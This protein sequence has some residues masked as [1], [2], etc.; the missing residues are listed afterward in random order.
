MEN[1]ESAIEA[2]DFNQQGIAL[3]KAGNYE[4][5]AKKYDKAIEIDPMVMESYIN[6]G[7]LYLKTGQYQKAKNYYKKALLF[8]KNGEVYFH[9]G[10]A[11]FM[12]DEPGEGLEYYNLAISAG[13]NND[14]MLF[15][16]GMAYENM[17][18]NG[19][20]L[21][22]YTKAIQ[23]NHMR[24]EYKVKKI[25][26]MIKLN[27]MDEVKKSVD[28]LIME[29][30]ELFDGY[31]LKTLILFEDNDYEKAAEFAKSASE[32][33]PS[34]TDLLY[35]YARAVSLTGRLDD[36][37]KIIENAKKLKFFDESKDRFSLLECE[38]YATGG[39]YDKALS[40]SEECLKLIND[41]VV[42]ANIRFMRINML[43]EKEKYEEALKDADEIINSSDR[44]S[45]YYAALYYKPF[46]YKKLGRNNE[47]EREYKDSITLYRLATLQNP[48]AVDAYMYRA[49][50]LR[51]IEKFDEAIDML[52][53]VENIND[54]LAE[55]HTIKADIYK[56]MGKEV[57]YKE[58]LNKAYEIKP[59]LK[60]VINEGGD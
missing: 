36:A 10:N 42:L 39:E 2:K 1:N 31:H 18:D 47:A 9:Y 35:D 24:P 50:C 40:K 37:I 11:C 32:R 43:I 41:D 60:N 16:M 17:D 46:C 53:F 13:F 51:D 3:F 55:I 38:I 29:E 48:D 44:G 58:E 30:P 21:R 52:E 19:M 4:E 26:T 45:F 34:D 22:Y 12:N 8:E 14:E 25:E 5:A 49:M 20:A 56:M 57:L 28:E 33:F 7:N 27:M 6:Y 54:G 23:K 59:E 15:F